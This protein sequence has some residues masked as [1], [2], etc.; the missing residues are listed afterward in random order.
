MID[1]GGVRAARAAYVN[2][3]V[4]SALVIFTLL[5]VSYEPD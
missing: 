4:M 5:P 2:K 1:G 3:R